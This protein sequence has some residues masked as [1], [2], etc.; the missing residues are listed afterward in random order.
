M[1][2]NEPAAQYIV[3]AAEVV[4][5]YHPPDWVRTVFRRRYYGPLLPI[6][7]KRGAGKPIPRPYYEYRREVFDYGDGQEHEIAFAY[8]PSGDYIGNPKTA[9]YLV[10]KRGLSDLQSR[11]GDPGPVQ[12]GFSVPEQKWYGWSHRAIYGFGIGS[13]CK[14]GD[15]GYV[16]STPSE[17]FTEATEKDEDGYAWQK[18]EN[19]RILNDPT[20]EYDSRRGIEIFHPMTRHTTVSKD[21]ELGGWTKAE[22]DI[23]FVACG[24]GEWTARNM[25]DALE[26]A[27]DFAEGVS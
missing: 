22:P 5:A 21:G 23:Q 18:P 20:H 24:R 3:D 11:N 6:H 17:L 26:M 8:T 12:I 7:V 2:E 25:Q 16:P 1:N 15:C 13:T 9:R 19:V 14:K 4:V 27:R 10:I